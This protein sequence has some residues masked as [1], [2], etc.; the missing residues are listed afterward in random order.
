MNGIPTNQGF[1]IFGS[2]SKGRLGMNLITCDTND[3]GIDDLILKENGVFALYVLFGKE[4]GY[5]TDFSINTLTVTTGYH[6]KFP[7]DM[8]ELSVQ[9]AGD[10][11]GD[12][13]DDLALSLYTLDQ[14]Y[15]IYGRGFEEPVTDIDIMQITPE[16]GFYIDGIPNTYFGFSMSGPV[17]FNNDGYDDVL[18]GAIG[19]PS[20]SSPFVGQANIVYGGPSPRTNINISSM[21]LD[22]GFGITGIDEMAYFAYTI[23]KAGD[24]NGDG[25]DDF[26]IGAMYT[27]YN[28]VRMTGVVYVFLN[29]RPAVTCDY[30]LITSVENGITVCLKPCE[31]DNYLKEET[32]VS[33]CL[34]P[35][36]PSVLNEVNLCTKPCE[37][38]EIFNIA[39]NSCQGSCYVPWI[40]TTIDTVDVCKKPC[41]NGEFWIISSLFPLRANTSWTRNGYFI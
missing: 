20:A 8:N 25:A 5:S 2:L 27:N 18:V 31:E 13:I 40:S 1:K 19:Y 11:N 6:I 36:I 34:A 35:W 17:D 33:E 4:G 39:S 10:V 22:Q 28:E 41:E 23:S 16:Q 14:A 9:R 24:I 32:C 7:T 12:G 30:P 29:G 3:D 26:L 21:T 15:V 37:E 38:G